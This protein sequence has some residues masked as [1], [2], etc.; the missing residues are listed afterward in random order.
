MEGRRVWRASSATLTVVVVFMLV[1]AVAVPLLAYLVWVDQDAWLVP[2]LLATLSLLALGYAWRFGWH[3]QLR[4]DREGVT[5][6]NPFSTHRFA[7]DDIRVLAP[8]ENGLVIASLDARAEAW[9]VQKSNSATRRGRRTRADRITDELFVLLEQHDPPVED[10][11]AGTRI[12]RARPDESRVL[13][14]LERAAGEEVLRTLHRSTGRPYPVADVTRRWRRLLHDPTVR[15][16]VLEHDG[17]AV[18][19][20]AFDTDTVRHL[21]VLPEHTRRGFGTALLRFATS[22]IF[23]G[24]APRA[25]LWVLEGDTGT[26]AFGRATGWTETPER[27]EAELWEGLTQLR[28]ERRN[29]TAPRRGR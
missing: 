19:V 5:V 29:P 26:R 2:A 11:T 10:E 14:R 15:V 17:E 18:G 24:G 16:H 3:P 27:R 23:D 22:E 8:G 21:A 20:V 6:V 4:A 25:A 9:C 12:R 7:W 28:L 1:A 13:T